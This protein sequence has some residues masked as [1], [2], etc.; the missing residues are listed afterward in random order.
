MSEPVT[1]SV[2]W[3]VLHLFYRGVGHMF[4]SEAV[5]AAVKSAQA[6]DHQ[7]VVFAVLGHKADVGFMALGPDLWRLRQ[8]QTELGS[9]GLELVDSYVSL[10]E[11]S[12]YA[13]GM[14]PEMLEPRLHPVLPPEGKRAMCFYP[15]SKRRSTTG[16]W[17][18]LPFDERREL[19]NAHG[20]TGRKYAGQVS[21]L[22]TGSTG[23]D[24][25]EWSVTLFAED[26]ADLKKCVY[27]MRFD[28]GSAIYAEFGTFIT[29]LVA[30]V[31]EVIAGF[32][33]A[34]F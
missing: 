26:P 18:M 13:A 29:G 4:D 33:P 15:M 5:V 20:K 7:V 14:P 1:P 12:E 19:M 2:G 25:W 8:L 32:S 28:S 11:I 10:T 23:L 9:A 16:N 31:E 24:D 27:E 22:V 34:S 17:Y 3:G 21:Q 30:P 6:D